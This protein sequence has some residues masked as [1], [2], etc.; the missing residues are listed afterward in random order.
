MVAGVGTS[1]INVNTKVASIVAEGDDATG[2]HIVFRALVEPVRQI[3]LNAGLEGSVVVE[4]LKGEKVGVGFNAATGGCV[5]MLAS[6][7]VDPAKLNRF[8]L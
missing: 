4:R 2:I 1:L 7:I 8:A 6:G 3:A 5:N